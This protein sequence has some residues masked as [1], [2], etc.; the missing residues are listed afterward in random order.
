MRRSSSA[1][2]A[3]AAVPAFASALIV[4][5]SPGDATERRVEVRSTAW[6]GMHPAGRD[7][8][9]ERGRRRDVSTFDRAALRRRVGPT[10]SNWNRR[11]R[12]SPSRSP[13]TAP[14]LPAP[15]TRP[16]SAI[17]GPR[18]RS[19][20][21]IVEA[22]DV[23][24]ED[25]AFAGGKA[26]IEVL[27][28]AAG[29]KATGD[30][31]GDEARRKRQ[32]A[33]GTAGSSSGRTPTAPRSADG[34]GGDAAATSSP[35]AEVGHQARRRLAGEDPAATTS[36]SAPRARRGGRRN[37]KVRIVDGPASHAGR[38]TKSAARYRGRRRDPRM[39]RSLQRD[40]DRTGERGI[41]LAGDIAAG[42]LRQA[43]RPRSAATT[44]ASAATA[45]ARSAKTPTACSPRPRR[46]AA[47]PGPA[48]SPSAAPRPAK[49]T[50]SRAAHSGS[51]PKR[52][53]IS[54]PSATRSAS[55]R[56]AALRVAGRCRDRPLRRIDRTERRMIAGNRMILGADAVG[57]ETVFGH[58]L[59]TGNTIE[60]GLIGI[61][62]AAS[63][64]PGDA[65][66]ANTIVGT[67]AGDAI[68]DELNVVH[69]Q[70]RSRLGRSR[71]R[72]RRRWRTQPDRRRPGPAKRTRS[73][74]GSPGA[75]AARS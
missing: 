47:S 62:T 46:P 64:G 51:S 34:E 58:A 21:L 9:R 66:S 15:L 73:K 36:A 65:I 12:R 49:R 19:R 6:L 28:G 25:V 44:S 23:T 10:K 55:P 22:A 50:T 14:P 24:I 61:E 37:R 3:L 1:L 4:V 43:A 16:P 32:P 39:R 26:G 74:A 7:R 54:A 27:G 52:R 57:I 2:I 63:E 8:G 41:D 29:F 38:T 48:R 17:V 56:T 11:C 70:Q 69:R 71:H 72:G 5:D 20:R 35:T 75:T 40:R 18:R 31:F 53:R 42:G 13:S 33:I 60:G 67:D 45:K 68:R 59:I 30:W